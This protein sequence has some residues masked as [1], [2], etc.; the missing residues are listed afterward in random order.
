MRP[1]YVPFFLSL[2]SLL[3]EVIFFHSGFPCLMS[4]PSV[5]RVLY[6]LET[7]V[8]STLSLVSRSK[9]P[10]QTQSTAPIYRDSLLPVSETLAS[11]TSLCF[12]LV[13]NNGVEPLTLCLQSRCS[14]QLS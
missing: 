6:T 1:Y 4:S 11:N 12:S 5:P 3:P 10:V 7:L 13:E 9:P 14:S 8:C 2:T